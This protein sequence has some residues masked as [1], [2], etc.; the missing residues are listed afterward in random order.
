[1]RKLGKHL[2]LHE[3]EYLLYLK[4][5]EDLQTMTDNLERLVEP[6]QERDRE[7]LRLKIRE[8]EIDSKL[9]H[10]PSLNPRNWDQIYKP[11]LES[12]RKYFYNDTKIS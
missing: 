11:W 12:F 6:N 4:I 3:D 10:A 1:M 7:I 2:I 9:R 8:E 5:I